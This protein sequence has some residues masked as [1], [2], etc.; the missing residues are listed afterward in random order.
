MILLLKWKGYSSLAVQYRWWLT[1]LLF[2][3]TWSHCNKLLSNRLPCPHH[4]STHLAFWST[5]V[6]G[7]LCSCI[8]T[9]TP[10]AQCILWWI[11]REGRDLEVNQSSLARLSAW[12]IEKQD[13]RASRNSD[14]LIFSGHFS[15]AIMLYLFIT[16]LELGIKLGDNLSDTRESLARSYLNLDAFCKK[17]SAFTICCRILTTELTWHRCISHRNNCIV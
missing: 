11:V 3:G 6:S 15:V 10:F 2:S 4:F 9:V 8:V 14:R 12:N 7:L 5:T 13:V 16:P 1:Q 17:R